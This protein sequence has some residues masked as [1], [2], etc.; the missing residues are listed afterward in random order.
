MKIPTTLKTYYLIIIIISIFIQIPTQAQNHD[1]ITQKLKECPALKIHLENTYF[2]TTLVDNKQSLVLYRFHAPEIGNYIYIVWT[3]SSN[4]EHLT[5]LE[6]TYWAYRC[7]GHSDSEPK[8]ADEIT[9]TDQITLLVPSAPS[10]PVIESIYPEGDPIK[11]FHSEGDLWMNTWADDDNLY[12][13]WGDGRGVAPRPEWTDCGIAR[14]SRTLP[15]ITAEERCYNAPTATPDVNDKPSS[16]LFIDGRL[17][18]HFHS[19]LGD[20]WIGYLA[21]SDNYGETWTRVGFYREWEL[22]PINGSPWTRDRNSRF[23]CQFFINMGK[24]YELNID[25]YVY[26]LAIGKEWNWFGGVRL[27]RVGKEDI[28]DYSAYQYFT[29]IENNEPQWSSSQ[30]D[31]RPI[32]GVSTMDQG[33]AMYHPKLKRYLFFTARELYDAPNPWGPWTFA[34]SWTGDQ[35]PVQWKGGYQPGII[36]KDTGKNYFWF[37]ISGQNDPPRITYDLNLGKMVMKLREITDVSDFDRI[38]SEPA[39]FILDQNYPNPFNSNTTIKFSIPNEEQIQLIVYDYLGRKAA[40]LLNQKIS[41]G[42]QSLVYDAKDLS[43]GIYI[44]HLKTS[45]FSQKRKMIIIK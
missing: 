8:P 21:Y 6:G 5:N 25:G 4:K 37:T 23:R 7:E 40:V 15:Q 26:T 32:P 44:L 19:P 12:S 39:R 16:L 43:S 33:S 10:S 42:S 13:G 14:F 41:R 18:G 20:A 31:A 45:S 38:R 9:V 29:G 34:G 36:S 22:S 11:P 28:L 35:I 3:R 30:F 27:T 24:N 17:Y 1:E 2:D